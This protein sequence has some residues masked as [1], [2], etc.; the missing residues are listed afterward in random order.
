MIVSRYKLLGVL[1]AFLL[2][3]C[4]SWLDVEPYDKMTE[5]QVY[6]S[7]QGIQK[8]LNGLYLKMAS[9][10][11]YARELSCGVL[12]VLAQRYYISDSEHSYYK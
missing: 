3:G 6:A 9:E 10:D 12:D 5:D 2:S 4:N 11:L 8:N 1:V 7:E